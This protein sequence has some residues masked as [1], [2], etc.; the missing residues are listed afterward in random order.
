VILADLSGAPVAYGW[1]TDVDCWIAVPEAASFRLRPPSRTVVAFAEPHA[2]P[3][4]VVD[5]YLTT[6]LPL[7]LQVVL[8]KQALHASAVRAADGVVAF[9]GHSHSGKTTLAYAF[10]RRG[11]ALWGDD[12]LAVDATTDVAMALRVPFALNLRPATTAYFGVE[13]LPA[14][15][16]APTWA[17]ATLA[18]IMVLDPGRNAPRSVERLTG[19]STFTA[20]LAHRYVFRPQTSAEKAQSV[21]DYLKIAAEV[22][23]FRV[24]HRARFDDLPELLEQ[25]EEVL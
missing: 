25:I 16:P 14:P 13:A 15:A 21:R 17:S 6:A 23:V 8:R 3:D 22:P 2:D 5:A 20:L 18:A 10:S 1:R 11:Y 19:R 4:D 24:R 7:A 12:V 9:C